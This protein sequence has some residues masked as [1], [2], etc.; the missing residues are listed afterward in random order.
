[1]PNTDRRNIACNAAGEGLWGYGW[2]LA[3]PLTVLPLLVERLGGTTF[4]IGLLASISTAGALF[5]QVLSPFILQT[6]RGKKRFLILYHLFV[7]LPPWLLMGV[8]P[9]VLYGISA[10]AARVSLLV[11]YTVFMC[12]NGFIVPVWLDWVAGLFPQ[13]VR[14][15]A[16]GWSGTSAAAGSVLAALSAGAITRWLEFP[17]GYALL[18]FIGGGFYVASMVAFIP[19]KEEALTARAR[20]S[21]GEVFSRFKNSLSDRSFRSYLVS[22]LLTTAGT[23]PVAFFAVHYGSEGGGSVAEETLIAL[24]AVV[25][26]S[27][28]AVGYLLGRLGDAHGHRI[29]AALG[30]VAQAAALVVSGLMPGVGACAIVFAMTGAGYASGWVSHHNLLFETCPHDCRAAHITVSNLVL[31]PATAL[32]PL[33]TGAAVH[34]FGTG[35]VFLLCLVPTALG[36]LWLLALVREPRTVEVGPAA[37]GR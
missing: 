7:L 25:W 23:G 26:L 11:S 15:R 19:T 28:A 24:G 20:M 21:R 5:P 2:N 17:T 29:G 31:A 32:V 6:G 30:G 27:Q 34:A 12:C 4:E 8:S 10:P 1:V 16:F 22:R 36:L 35:T 3:A 13:G 14:G 9:L 37:D 33:A 18:F